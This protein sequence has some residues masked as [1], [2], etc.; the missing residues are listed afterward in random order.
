MAE[1]RPVLT[2][3]P[4]PLIWTGVQSIALLKAI[5]LADRADKQLR[6]VK[7][8]V[9]LYY[10]DSA[11]TLTPNDSSVVKPDDV[12][13]PDPG[14]WL[15]IGAGGSGWYEDHAVTVNGQ[16]VFTLT[17]TPIDEDT[18]EMDVFGGTPQLNGVDFAVSGVNVAYDGL[19]PLEIGEVVRFRFGTFDV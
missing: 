16:T 9:G 18:V 4:K 13:L 5:L 12:T 19:V 17:K 11:S 6:V 7:D 8:V 2:L 3:S 15:R 14:R 10:Y 1:I